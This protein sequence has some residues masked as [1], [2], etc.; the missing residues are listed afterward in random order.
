MKAI[1][2]KIVALSLFLILAGCTNGV[3]FNSGL[4]SHTVEPL[5]INPNPTEVRN[6]MKQ[7]RGY[8][9]QFE[10]QMVSIRVGKNGLGQVAKE[11]GLKIV[12]FA[13]IEKWSAV[14]GLWQMQ[15]VRIYGR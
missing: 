14:F 3:L 12:Y 10:Y 15:V 8:V 4:Y 1:H 6:S 13:D 11:H 7:A 9:N 5:T 2:R